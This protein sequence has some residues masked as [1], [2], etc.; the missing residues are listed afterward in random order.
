MVKGLLLFFFWSMIITIFYLPHF[1]WLKK[2]VVWCGLGSRTEPTRNSLQ[3]MSP[4]T[5]ENAWQYSRTQWLLIVLSFHSQSELLF[6]FL[7]HPPS[8]STSNTYSSKL[9]LRKSDSVTGIVHCVIYI[10]E[11][12]IL[13]YFVCCLSQLRSRPC[14]CSVVAMAEEKDAF[15]V[16]KKGDVVGIYKSFTD[17]QPLLAASSVYPFSNLVMFFPHAKL[18][19]LDY[20]F[21]LCIWVSMFCNVKL[22]SASLVFTWKIIK[23]HLNPK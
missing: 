19:S 18:L 3:K 9:W 12:Q 5:H 14:A 21:F 13:S 4:I 15:Y 20:L 8:I 17:I 10:D 11:L 7:H 1:S 6:S 23:V 22:L 16:V 2:Q